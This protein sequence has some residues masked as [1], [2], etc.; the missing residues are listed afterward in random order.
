LHRE[1]KR[2]RERE[3]E[4]ERKKERKKEIKIKLVKRVTI[5]LV[6][7]GQVKAVVSNGQY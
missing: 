2:E 3:R 4:R 7:I 1:R 6:K 5:T